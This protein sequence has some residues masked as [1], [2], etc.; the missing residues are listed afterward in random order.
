MKYQ[1]SNPRLLHCRQILYQQI[2]LGS[3]KVLWMVFKNMGTVLGKFVWQKWKN[4]DFV[5]LVALGPSSIS[6]SVIPLCMRYSF[7]CMKQSSQIVKDVELAF[8]LTWKSSCKKL[9]GLCEGC[10]P[11]GHSP[12]PVFYSDFPPQSPRENTYL[13]TH[14]AGLGIEA[15]EKG[16]AL[17]PLETKHRSCTISFPHAAHFHMLDLATREAKTS[18]PYS[19]Q[20]D[21]LMFRGSQREQILEDS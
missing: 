9:L 21:Q 6:W 12:F 5:E 16:H 1:G 18:K 7:G 15:G 4:L 8:P 13:P 10:N 19:G 14:F 11:M 20:R 17:F 2:Y 3:P